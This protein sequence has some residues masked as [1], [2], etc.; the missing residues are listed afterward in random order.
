MDKDFPASWEELKHPWTR[1]ELLTLLDELTVE[2][3]CKLWT[4]QRRRGLVIGFD[5]VVHF[6]FD[7][8]DLD[9]GDIHN[10]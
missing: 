8:H 2:D 7:D 4:E 10:R 5:E 9:T 6:L 1:R 3:P